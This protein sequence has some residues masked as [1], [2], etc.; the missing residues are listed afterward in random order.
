M[1]GLA[2]I[3]VVSR[4]GMVTKRYVKR[5]IG[6]PGDVIAMTGGT[7]SIN[8]E[9]VKR[10][11]LADFDVRHQDGSTRPT[12]H[13]Q[14]TLTNGVSYRVLD[15]DPTRTFAEVRVEADQVFVLGDN[16]DDSE[17]IEDTYQRRPKLAHQGLV[18]RDRVHAKAVSTSER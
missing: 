10:Q 11:R 17:D 9:T 7:L 13:Y 2:A 5:V 16:R 15:S 12:S 14:E 3:L 1:R 4:G 18:Q 6:L 8:G